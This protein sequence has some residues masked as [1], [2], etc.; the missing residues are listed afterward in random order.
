M[1]LAIIFSNQNTIVAVSSVVRASYPVSYTVPFSVWVHT[2]A[3]C[4]RAMTWFPAL[5]YCYCTGAKCFARCDLVERSF[6]FSKH[7]YSHPFIF[8]ILIYFVALS[9]FFHNYI[10]SFWT[11]LKMF[12]KNVYLM[13]NYIDLKYLSD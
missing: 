13:N 1:C 6:I 11:T 5:S 4:N 8:K 12:Y 2:G 10:I 3:S 7:Y 9:V